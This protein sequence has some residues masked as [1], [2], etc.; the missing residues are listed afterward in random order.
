[1]SIYTFDHILQK[2]FSEKNV[3]EL[4]DVLNTHTVTLSTKDNVT[5]LMAAA[6]SG[7]LESTIAL[8]NLNT[9][10]ITKKDN[11]GNTALDYARKGGHVKIEEYLLSCIPKEFGGTGEDITKTCKHPN[12][13]ILIEDGFMTCT[14]CA[15]VLESKMILPYDDEE[16]YKWLD[17]MGINNDLAKKLG[18]QNSLATKVKNTWDWLK[19]RKIRRIKSKEMSKDALYFRKLEIEINKPFGAIF[20]FC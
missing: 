17:D 3:E 4:L 6:N 10:V 20:P 12:R 7:C 11:N 5:P 16:F 19:K 8:A 9:A 1:M 14:N 2:S 13:N 18:M 15:T